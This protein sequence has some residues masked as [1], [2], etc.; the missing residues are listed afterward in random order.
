MAKPSLQNVTVTPAGQMYRD[1]GQEPQ[2][3]AFN[4]LL[5]ADGPQGAVASGIPVG[6]IY[7]DSTTSGI[8]VLLA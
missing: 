5:T 4:N 1:P 6:G 3:L 8:A 7:V 2:A